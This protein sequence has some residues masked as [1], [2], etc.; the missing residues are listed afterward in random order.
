[1][2]AFAQT[3]WV[4]MSAGSSTPCALGNRRD[5]CGR[6]RSSH[7]TLPT[8]QLLHFFLNGP[9]LWQC[10][11]GECYWEIIGDD[12]VPIW[13]AKETQEWFSEKKSE[14]KKKRCCCGWTVG[15]NLG[16]L[17]FAFLYF[18]SRLLLQEDTWGSHWKKFSGPIVAPR[19][20]HWCTPPIQMQIELSHQLQPMTHCN[21]AQYFLSISGASKG[22]S[23]NMKWVKMVQ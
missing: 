10:W 3:A 4:S 6:I 19:P 7:L 14:F 16:N 8:P 22:D 15:G 23:V 17:F 21:N 18:C 5:K 20:L 2:F 1:M 12:W 11:G 13:G 9:Y